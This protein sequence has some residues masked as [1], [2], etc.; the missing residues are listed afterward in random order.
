MLWNW[1]LGGS[2]IST[3]NS[4]TVLH[5]VFFSL[6]MLVILRRVGRAIAP[7]VAAMYRG[8]SAERPR[9]EQNSFVKEWETSAHIRSGSEKRGA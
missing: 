8:D 4:F 2:G 9:R 1:Y 7:A 3:G 6:L 5:A